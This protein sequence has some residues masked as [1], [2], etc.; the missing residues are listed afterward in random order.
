MAEEPVSFEDSQN[1]C[2]RC[3]ETTPRLVDNMAEAEEPVSRCIVEDP[4]DEW[5]VCEDATP[6]MECPT[7][8]FY[9]EVTGDIKKPIQDFKLFLKGTPF[10]EVSSSEWSD[11]ILYVCPVDLEAGSGIETILK[12]MPDCKPAILVLMHHTDDPAYVVLDSSSY[13]NERGILIVHLLYHEDKGLLECQKN[14]EARKKILE[15]LTSS[16]KWD[17]CEDAK[18]I[19]CPSVRFHSIVPG[20]I[21]KYIRTFKTSLVDSPNVTEVSTSEWSDVTLAFCP[22]VSRVGTDIEAALKNIEGTKPAILVA[23]HH[24]FEPEYVIPDTSRFGRDKGVLI[25]D[26]LFHEDSGL[27]KCKVNQ[28]AEE[29]IKR[30]LYEEY[31]TKTSH[32]SQTVDS[33]SDPT[34]WPASNTLW[35]T[36][37]FCLLHWCQKWDD[38]PYWTGGEGCN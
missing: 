28:E 13:E 10:T 22:I 7:L 14:D 20:S 27:L 35:P 34:T 36:R 4:Q 17:E 23:M 15:T 6:Q 30:C 31:K 37:L 21:R 25:V 11:I 24:T 19:E 32:S 38:D 12:E 16:E 33:N 9:S 18:D 2:D 3:D 5:D 8:R 26:C 29:V 1:A